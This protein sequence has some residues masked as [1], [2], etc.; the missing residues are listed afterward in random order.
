M[1]APQMVRK[2]WNYCDVLRHDG[3]SYG[4]YVE[5]FTILLFLKMA[6]ERVGLGESMVVPKGYDWPA[7]A[8]EQGE[9]LEQCCSRVAAWLGRVHQGGEN[10][11]RETPSH[12][13]GIQPCRQ[14]GNRLLDA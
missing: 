14:S 12:G 8:K 13:L 6:H 1:N 7:L 5:Q 3:L 9:A 2:L 4:D 11:L 10:P